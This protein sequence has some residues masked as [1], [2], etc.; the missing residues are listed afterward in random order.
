MM[1]NHLKALKYATEGKVF[2][3]QNTPNWIMWCIEGGT[4]TWVV[5]YD[6]HKESYSCNCKN[7]RLT[8]C[9]HIKAV[10]IGMVINDKEI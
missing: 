7:V 1:K 4:G 10:K 2:P 5:R 9:C 8:K 6:K 3:L